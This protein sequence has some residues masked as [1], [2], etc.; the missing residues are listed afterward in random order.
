MLER[1]RDLVEW[2][3]PFHA[4][5][6]MVRGTRVGSAVRQLEYAGHKG[7][8]VAIPL[9]GEP[10]IVG[11]AGTHDGAVFRQIYL[12]RELDAP[13]PFAPQTIVDAGANIGVATRYLARRFPGAQ[14]ISLEI[15]RDNVALLERN[16]THLRQVAVRQQALW[17]HRARVSIENPG[18]ETDGYRAVEEPGGAI[19]AIGVEELLDEAGIRTLDLL[20]MDI[21]GAEYAAI[22]DLLKSYVPITQLLIE[23]H[24]VIGDRASLGRT[25]RAIESLNA[26]GYRVFHISP[27]GF[28]YSFVRSAS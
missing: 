4:R 10:P 13:F 3:S 21:E 24:H 5:F 17:G 11:R 2:L 28:E 18:A 23:F 19:D 22:D 27:V 6:G 12:W 16:T 1:V 14:V 8:L 26:A 20:K 25:Q 7:A 9:A 15:D